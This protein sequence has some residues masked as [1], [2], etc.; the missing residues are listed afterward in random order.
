[1][2]AEDSARG[3]QIHVA[4]GEELRRLERATITLL[5]V[6]SL[7]G[8]ALGL[9]IGLMLDKRFG[10]IE[11]AFSVV[12]TTWFFA[13]GRAFDRGT[14]GRPL[15]AVQALMES[16]LP[17][18]SLLV[19]ASSQ[20]PVYALGSWVPPVIFY[21]LMLVAVARLQPRL[22]IAYGAAGALVFPSVY[23]AVLHAQL[24]AGA[25]LFAQPAMQGTRSLTMFTSGLLCAFLA[26]GLL[27]AIGRAEKNVRAQD[28]FGKYRLV[29]EIARGGMG[30]VFEALYC[31][32]AASS[33]ASRSSASTRTWRPR[34]SSSSPSA[35]RPSSRRAS[36]T[37]PSCRCSISGAS[38]TRIS[39]SWSSSRG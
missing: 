30:F 11:A 32:R 33:G 8:V 6:M 39:W 7:M 14:V 16:L 10:F 12:T 31:P 13:Y 4:L 28:L 1:M 17:W 22:C 5:T 37:P 19:V 34:R 9:G 24:P 15:R 35:E 26:R 21:A 2:K 23:F 29:R 25:P 38:T 20:G 18:V 3:A 27:A 36:P